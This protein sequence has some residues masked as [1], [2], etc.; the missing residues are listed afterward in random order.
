LHEQQKNV[1]VASLATCV[2]LKV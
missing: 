1:A 2:E